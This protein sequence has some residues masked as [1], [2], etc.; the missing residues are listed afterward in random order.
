MKIKAKQAWMYIP[1][2]ICEDVIVCTPETPSRPSVLIKFP[3]GEEFIMM[4]LSCKKIMEMDK[5]VLA[6]HF[7]SD[8]FKKRRKPISDFTIKEGVYYY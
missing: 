3:W 4:G 7:V 1:E 2:L 5:S 8:K 6:V